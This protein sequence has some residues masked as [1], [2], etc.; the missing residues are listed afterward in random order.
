M[1]ASGAY[2]CHEES[3]TNTGDSKCGR[4]KQARYCSKA[5]QKL[6]WPKHK[7]S[8][9]NDVG[10]FHTSKL[11]NILANMLS[12]EGGW[13]QGIN[14]KRAVKRL[15]QSFQFW[16]EDNYVFQ[17]NLIQ[18]YAEAGGYQS[19]EE[20]TQQFRDYV[21]LAKSKKLM[22][23]WWDEDAENE[24]WVV[25]EEYIH[26]AIEKSDIVEEY[27]YSSGEHMVLR[28]MASTIFGRSVF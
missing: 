8:C 14:R 15:C 18:A 13:F 11:D 9:G 27:G 12:G 25:A 20:T 7:Q 5:C 4:C 10:L 28:S 21:Q 23:S 19:R 26:F 17:Q 24:L 6:D 16:A 2:Q 3:C 22:P 1:S